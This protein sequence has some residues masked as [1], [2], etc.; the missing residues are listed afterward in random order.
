MK[1]NSSIPSSMRSAKHAVQTKQ[2]K[3]GTTAYRKLKAL[4]AAEDVACR[5][6]K[7]L[8][9]WW[10]NSNKL[11]NTVLTTRYYDRLGLPRLSC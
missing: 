1:T 4:G 7:Y 6:A 10:S 11:L 8:R 5:V 9:R 2:W 3:R